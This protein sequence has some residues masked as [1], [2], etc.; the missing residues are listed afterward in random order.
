VLA[1]ALKAVLHQQRPVRE[2]LAEAQDA[3][4]A[5]VTQAGGNPD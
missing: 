4:R 1:P 5:A 3:A 2:V